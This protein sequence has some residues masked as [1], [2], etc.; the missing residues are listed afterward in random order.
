MEI[1]GRA[2]RFIGTTGSAELGNGSERHFGGEVIKELEDIQIG[3]IKVHLR[4][5]GK[6][7]ILKTLQIMAQ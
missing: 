2:I 4:A 3:N 6:A 5:H 1:N 7:L